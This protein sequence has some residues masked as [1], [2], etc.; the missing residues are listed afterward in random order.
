MTSLQHQVRVEPDRR[1][2]CSPETDMNG[3]GRL[4]DLL[5]RTI[6]ASRRVDVDMATVQFIDSTGIGAPITQ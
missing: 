3:S 6:H 4:L 1:R 5:N 2:S